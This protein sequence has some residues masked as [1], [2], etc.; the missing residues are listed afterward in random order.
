MCSLIILNDNSVLF[1][2][3]MISVARYIQYLIIFE[4]SLKAIMY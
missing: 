2:P 4:K 1:N 3:N